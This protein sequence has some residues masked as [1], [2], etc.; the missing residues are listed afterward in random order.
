MRTSQTVGVRQQFG[1][2]ALRV[3]RAEMKANVSIN[4][5]PRGD[6]KLHFL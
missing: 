6:V 3:D 2:A 1:R 4:I 5:L